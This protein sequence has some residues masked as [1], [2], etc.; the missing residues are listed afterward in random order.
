MDPGLL[1]LATVSLAVF[2]LLLS[3]LLNHSNFQRRAEQYHECALK[4]AKLYNRLRVEKSKGDP[5]PNT[6]LELT[7]DYENILDDYENHEQ[8]DFDLFRATR[9]KYR[10]HNITKWT[11]YR[12]HFRY[13]VITYFGYHCLIVLPFVMLL[14]LICG[15]FFGHEDSL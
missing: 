5:E 7:E 8:V 9:P 1:S 11:A 10:D 4:I 15:T 2:I 14:F 12:Y 6:I 3:L 13:Y